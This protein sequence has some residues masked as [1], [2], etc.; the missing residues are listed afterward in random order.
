MQ[1]TLRKAD[2]I[3]KL[4]LETARKLHLPHTVSVSVF[5]SETVP[6]AID[7]VRSTLAA[8][9]TEAKSLIEAAFA[10]RA[11]ISTANAETAVNALLGEK[12]LADQMEKTIQPFAK[13]APHAVSPADSERQRLAL[14]VRSGGASYYGADEVTAS[15][16]TEEFSA[17]MAAEMRALRKKK[18]EISDRLTEINNSVKIAIP[19]SV[20]QTLARN[21]VI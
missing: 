5:S 4:A 7:R 14:Q 15:V 12:A 11:L 1:V 2:A 3:S 21:H 20:E 13:S 17:L 19:E 18:V 8:N 9:L 10:I 6:E 16:S